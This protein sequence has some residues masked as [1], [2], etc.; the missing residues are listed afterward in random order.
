M[1]YAMVVMILSYEPLISLHVQTQ[2]ATCSTYAVAQKVAPRE[3]SLAT[4]L[5]SNAAHCIVYQNIQLYLAS[6][7]EYKNNLSL[8]MICALIVHL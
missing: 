7:T 6:R 3:R 5:S 2:R 8:V 4:I 1:L